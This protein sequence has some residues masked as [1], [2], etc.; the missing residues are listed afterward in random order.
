[1]KTDTFIIILSSTTSVQSLENIELKKLW[2]KI[3]NLII[4]KKQYWLKH[5]NVLLN[6]L[7]NF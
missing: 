6:H 2:Q 1:M 3:T 7:H 4:Q 5:V